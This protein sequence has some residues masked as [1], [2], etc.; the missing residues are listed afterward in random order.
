MPV[1]RDKVSAFVVA[2]NRAGIIGTCLRAIRFADEV[3]VVDKSSTDGTASIAAHH[4]D[5]VVT[6]PWSETVEETRGFAVSLC[7][8]DWILFLDDDECRSPEAARF[9]AVELAA[10][11]AEIYEFPLRHY[12]LG[13]HDEDSYYWPEHH[14][15]LLRRG[16]VEFVATVHG[17]VSCRSDRILRI[18]AETGVCI[19]HLSHR[20]V[21]QWIEK[22][23]RYTSRGDR[24]RT[25]HAGQDL[26]AFAHAR[27]DHWLSRTR[28]VTPG[29]YPATVALLRATY[30]LIDRLK[31][32]EEESG[33]DGA[34]EFRRICGELD[35]AHGGAPTDRTTVLAVAVPAVAPKADSDSG[36]RASLRALR[37]QHDE[38]IRQHRAAT[39]QHR[40]ATET[41]QAAVTQR[42]SQLQEL[43]ARHEEM[44]R[45]LAEM[46]AAKQHAE[47]RAAA[48]Q[49]ALR[50]IENSRCWRA[51]AWPRR[52]AGRW[53][54]RQ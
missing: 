54:S 34:E 40:A 21:A 35:S 23:N 12:I 16:A 17:G 25:E 49:A 42:D 50:A 36:L 46:Q 45:Q 6:V 14:A 48:S 10:P 53:R 9:V 52:L 33:V 13:V 51:T 4:A 1:Q 43:S 27:I 32:W 30:D 38:A 22:T 37:A 28:D 20:N 24:V 31:I 29:G 41:Y 19:H 11:R 39:D 2:Y 47:A 8:H 44:S 18:D 5:R 26:I 3:I 7:S 15:R